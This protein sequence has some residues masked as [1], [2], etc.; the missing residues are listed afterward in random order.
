[1]E[2]AYEQKQWHRILLAEGLDGNNQDYLLV[3]TGVLR[4]PR[5]QYVAW[6][7]DATE[8]GSGV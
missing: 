2:V 7:L 6:L 5:D 4:I 1:M 3:E 8:I